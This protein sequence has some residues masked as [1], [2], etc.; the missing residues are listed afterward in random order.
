MTAAFAHAPANE[1]SRTPRG[2]H[3]QLVKPQSR[4]MPRELRMAGA[5]STF[6]DWLS[7]DVRDARQVEKHLGWS[8][9]MSLRL[10]L[11]S[12]P[13]PVT[14]LVLC[15]ELRQVFGGDEWPAGFY[16]TESGALNFNAPRYGL[17]VPVWRKWPAALQLYRHVGD[18]RPRWVSSADHETGASAVASIHAHA[19][20]QA[21]EEV[22]RAFVVSHTLEAMAVA[23]KHE[24]STVGLNNVS[25]W[26]APAQLFESFPSLRGVVLAMSDVPPRLERELQDAGLAVSIWKGGALL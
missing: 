22:T 19:M 25:A 24:V 26:C 3:L 17:I 7:L 12:T 21:P 14:S 23:I 4:P 6:A 10:G 9:E 20:K 1:E 13:G 11:R 2:S 8:P 5:L 15:S 16:V 18:T